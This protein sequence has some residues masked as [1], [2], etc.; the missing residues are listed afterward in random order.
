MAGV[1]DPAATT[2]VVYVDGQSKGSG[3]LGQPMTPNHDE[4]RIGIDWDFGC[5]MAGVI[6][7]VRISSVAVTPA[8]SCPAR[9][10]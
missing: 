3:S 5:A 4:L 7:E 6:D 8:P 9:S 10:S 1:Y 2:A